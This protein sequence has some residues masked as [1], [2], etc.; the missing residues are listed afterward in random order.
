MAAQRAFSAAALRRNELVALAT[1]FCVPAVGAALLHYARGLLSDPDRYL[2]RFLIGLFVIA[3]S[4]KPMLH[5]SKLAKRS[6]SCCVGLLGGLR[7]P[8]RHSL[9]LGPE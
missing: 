6:K 7:A 5:F 1:T 9:G 8:A 2:N 4:V 3:S